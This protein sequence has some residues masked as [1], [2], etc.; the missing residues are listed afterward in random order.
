MPPLALCR[1]DRPSVAEGG[2]WAG[3]RATELSL[4]VFCAGSDLPIGA[5]GVRSCLDV[6]STFLDMLGTPVPQP[7]SEQSPVA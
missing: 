6:V 7:V 2:R 5:R 4:N 1:S 3:V